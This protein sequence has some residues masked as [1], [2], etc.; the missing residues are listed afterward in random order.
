MHN[1]DRNVKPLGN[2]SDIPGGMLDV[3]TDDLEME[4]VKVSSSR[5][6]FNPTPT[7]FWVDYDSFGNRVV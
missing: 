5:H 7:T 1:V 2:R 3:E 6:E 4:T